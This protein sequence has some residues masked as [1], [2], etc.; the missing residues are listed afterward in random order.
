MK[1]IKAVVTLV[2]DLFTKLLT[3]LGD[4][5]ME[6]SS[7]S[8]EFTATKDSVTGKASATHKGLIAIQGVLGCIG[9]MYFLHRNDY[10]AAAGIVIASVITMCAS[11]R[12]T[13]SGRS[14][15]EATQKA[16]NEATHTSMDQN[17]RHERDMDIREKSDRQAERDDRQAERDHEYRM[18]T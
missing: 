6:S 15:A 14:H 4:L 3:L 7:T 10:K 9:C 16:N 11:E 5:I 13:E 8:A 1:F 12:Y 17:A 18:K 2:T